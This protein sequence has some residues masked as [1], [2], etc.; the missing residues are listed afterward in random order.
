MFLSL[1]EETA[2]IGIKRQYFH[3][4]YNEFDVEPKQNGILSSHDSQSRVFTDD[5]DSQKIQI[6]RA[7]DSKQGQMKISIVKLLLSSSAVTKVKGHDISSVGEHI[8][9]PQICS[10]CFNSNTDPC[11]HLLVEVVDPLLHRPEL[12]QKLLHPVRLL[13]ELRPHDVRLNGLVHLVEGSH[14][15]R[16]NFAS[17]LG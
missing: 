16:S 14:S 7:R 10:N 4:W 2:K 9:V 1:F 13:G 12:N 11:L 3:I 17:G 8:D 5:S 6:H 15:I